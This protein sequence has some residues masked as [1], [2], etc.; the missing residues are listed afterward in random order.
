MFLIKVSWLVQKSDASR[1]LL[2]PTQKPSWPQPLEE[3]DC[4]SVFKSINIWDQ[5][6]NKAESSKIKS[7]ANRVNGCLTHFPQKFLFSH[8]FN[9]YFYL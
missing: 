9:L 1:M 5:K 3:T 7:L 4:L 8:I 6:A 2:K